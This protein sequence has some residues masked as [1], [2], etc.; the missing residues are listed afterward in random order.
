MKQLLTCLNLFLSFNLFGQ[1][2]IDDIGDGWKCRVE[3]AIDVIK[4]CD[5]EKYNFLLQ[6][7]DHIS[8]SLTPYSTNEEG[9]I[10]L[11]SQKEILNGNINNLAAV[12]IHE[13]YHLY[14]INSCIYVPPNKEEV[15]CYLYELSFL[16]VVPNVEPWLIE[17]AKNQI[18]F[19]S[20]F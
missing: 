13:S 1:I 5:Q 11:I 2:Q 20:K 6:Y 7:C 17:H 14:F 19:Y 4:Q 3:Q 12:L 10:I 16:C 8:F 18:K 9:H 15:S